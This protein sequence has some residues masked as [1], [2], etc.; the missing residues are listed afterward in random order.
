MFLLG[1]AIANDTFPLSK[2][3]VIKAM[4]NN[5]NSRFDDM[6]LKTIEYGYEAVKRNIN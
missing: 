2:E 5:L 6:N 3:S 1:S 4:K